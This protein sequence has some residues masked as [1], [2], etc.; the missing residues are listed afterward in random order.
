MTALTEWIAAGVIVI[1]SFFLLVGA[2]GLARLPDF[3]MRLHAPTKASTLGVGGVLVASMLVAAG[4]GSSC[5]LGPELVFVNHILL[6]ER[7][8]KDVE[9]C[10]SREMFNNELCQVIK[11]S[12][13]VI[14]M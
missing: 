9:G 2:I 14:A 1:A 7:R 6:R 13:V 12:C 8:W 5:G 11:S 4:Q 10:D 3:Y